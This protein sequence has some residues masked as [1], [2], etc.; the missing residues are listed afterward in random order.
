MGFSSWAEGSFLNTSE[1]D[2]CSRVLQRTAG[3]PKIWKIHRKCFGAISSISEYPSGGSSEAGRGGPTEPW[4]NPHPL[5]KPIPKLPAL[6]K[7]LAPL[8]VLD[9][10][11]QIGDLTPKLLSAVCVAAPLAPFASIVVR[12]PGPKHTELLLNRSGR[13]AA[14]L[15]RRNIW[16]VARW[17]RRGLPR[18]A[19]RS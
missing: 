7:V 2:E 12:V 17:T 16:W 9:A 19:L 3:G 10:G 15:S 18:P 1:R 4:T 14:A 13:L 11:G 6:R 8:P 5:I